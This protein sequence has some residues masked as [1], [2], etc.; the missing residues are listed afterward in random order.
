MPKREGVSQG[1][2]DNCY[3]PQRDVSTP[4][5]GV[6]AVI[7]HGVAKPGGRGDNGIDH[8]TAEAA[9]AP[10]ATIQKLSM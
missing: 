4:Y 1:K 10:L 3:N 7:A 9:E 6:D 2:H 8:G 5:L